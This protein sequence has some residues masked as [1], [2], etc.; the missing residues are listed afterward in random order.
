MVFTY[1]TT[2]IVFVAILVW[3]R[4]VVTLLFPYICILI[5][6]Y[7][8][9]S[10]YISKYINL[11]S[12][13]VYTSFTVIVFWGHLSGFY[14]IRPHTVIVFRGSLSWFLE[15]YTYFTFIVFWGLYLVFWWCF[16]L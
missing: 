5:C 1:R 3:V 4:V 7:L 2:I 11:V 16:H 10:H 14:C 8:S 6:L 12:C 15:G 13:G 9:H